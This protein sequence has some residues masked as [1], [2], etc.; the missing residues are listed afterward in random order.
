MPQLFLPGFPDGASKIGSYVSVLKKENR[1]TYFVG[2]DN[3]FSHKV[4]DKAGL[5]HAITTLISNRHM[6]ASEAETSDLGIPHRT[7]MHWMQQY[8]QSGPGV[9]Y[10]PRVVRGGA[11]ITEAKAI[12]CGRLLDE[13]QRITEVARL[14]GVRES[15]LRKAVAN[16]RI[17]RHAHI[18]EKAPSESL[19]T[20]TKSER[21]QLDAQASEGLGTAC[22]RVD[23]RI[24]AAFGL[25]QS[26]PARFERCK[27][28]FMGGLL[29]GLP[30]LCANGLFSGL[31]K[32]LSLPKGFYSAL[33]ILMLLGFMA[34]G[35]LRRPEALRHVPPGEIGKVV[36]LDR[37]PEARTLREKIAMM[38]AAGTPLAW[39]KEL[40]RTWMA[41]D[42]EEAGYLYVDGHVR[43]YH[44]RKTVL[45]RRYVS[46][47][48]LCLRGTTDYWV[49]DAL[50]R[51]FF[52]V[53]K[54]LTDGLSATLLNEIV[55]ELLTSVPCQPSEA[56]LAADPLLHRFVVVFDR[57]GATHSLLSALWGER[58]GAVTYRKAVADKWDESEFA[59]LDVPVPGGGSTRMKLASKENELKAGKK[60]I[61]VLEVR[62]LTETGHQTAVITTALR[63]NDPIIAG[64]MFAR[65]CQENFFA[66]MM[67]HYD[68]DGLVQYGS[69]DIPGTLLVVNPVWRRL[70]K[71]IGDKR[72]HIRTLQAKL[73]AATMENDERKMQMMAEHMQ[74]IQA[75]QADV[76]DLSTKRRTT[77]RKA[78]LSMLPEAERPRQLLPLAKVLTDTVKMIAYRAETAL[79][80]LIRSHLKKPDEARAL[81]RE[82][83]VSSADIIPDEAEGTLTI[84][85]HRMVCPAH[86]KAVRALLNDL[87]QENFR[88]PET[89][90]R[91][92]YTLA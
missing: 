14:A 66:Y 20:T 1:I 26:A 48:R 50:G 53:S 54:T 69:E 47:E 5:Q 13:G 35:R 64:R 85:I 3:Y 15:T 11:V 75:L 55:P 19:K 46:R 16:G 78:P 76:A 24:S 33:H 42:P 12:E 31:G 59:V 27:D 38:S 23:E 18:T 67:Q 81:I 71:C 65:W 74:D 8:E 25:L 4:D 34:L 87:N 7:L 79:V 36:G 70:D 29:V 61:P 45:P 9:F 32:H 73:G 89:N 62:R 30:A 80:E 40:S 28:V 88:H 63:L 39:M 57:E 83:L 37:S 6:R 10:K 92:I 60:S 86:D 49:N 2:C 90:A 58:V 84:N 72:R 56:E 91:M 68:I 17:P 43:V 21:C 52:V 44:G 41:A 51:P 22:T 82:L 77:P